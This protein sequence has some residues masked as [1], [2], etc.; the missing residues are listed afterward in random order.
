MIFYTCQY[1]F[2]IDDH[3]I[4]V[5]SESERKEPAHYEKG[6]VIHNC[7]TVCYCVY[8]CITSQY[9]VLYTAK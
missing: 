8:V 5:P 6:I 7:I 3:G 9:A 2:C 4:E 1:I